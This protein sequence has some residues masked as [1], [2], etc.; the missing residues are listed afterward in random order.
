MIRLIC[1]VLLIALIFAVG[2]P[3]LAQDEPIDMTP[4][5]VVVP[6]QIVR[7]AEVFASI[8]S[9]LAMFAAGVGPLAQVVTSF[10]KFVTVRWFPESTAARTLPVV[11]LIVPVI[12]TVIYWIADF[13]GLSDL[14]VVVANNLITIV[15]IFISMLGAFVG[16]QIIYQKVMKPLDVPLLGKSG[17]QLERKSKA[18]YDA[19][20]DRERVASA[21]AIKG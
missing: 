8:V 12:I 3:T 15:P 16:Q 1:F 2:V 21:N 20:K 13:A 9:L 4:D 10:Y 17:Y 5:G 19:S 14:Y 7:P 11:A 18:Y 6:D